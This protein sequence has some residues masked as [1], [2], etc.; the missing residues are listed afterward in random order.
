[1]KIKKS[2]I[3]NSS[4]ISY[5]ISSPDRISIDTIYEAGFE[6]TNRIEDLKSFN[7]IE[8]LI[9]FVDNKPCNWVSRVTGPS[10]FLCETKEWYLKAKEIIEQG[11]YV[12]RICVERNWYE[13]VERFERA[14]KEIDCKLIKRNYD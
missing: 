7:N 8:D 3:T 5:L 1:M 9:S 11:N 2:F 12:S 14:L 4:S 6:T 10:R 13:D